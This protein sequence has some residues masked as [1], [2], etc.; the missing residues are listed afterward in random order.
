MKLKKKKLSR[1]SCQKKW[2]RWNNGNCTNTDIYIHWKSPAPSAWKVVTLKNL[3]QQATLVSSRKQ[4]LK[5]FQHL[6]DVFC[7]I[8]DY[9]ERLVEEIIINE[10]NQQE[11]RAMPVKQFWHIFVF[12]H[13]FFIGNLWCEKM[14]LWTKKF[15]WPL[16]I[17]QILFLWRNEVSRAILWL[18]YVFKKCEK[19]WLKSVWLKWTSLLLEAISNCVIFCG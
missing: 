10:R 17:H 8:N 11:R 19:M 9:P 12:W 3:I 6:K 7:S 5:E 13:Y 1:R 14:W 16:F 2:D 4:A 15:F 18:V